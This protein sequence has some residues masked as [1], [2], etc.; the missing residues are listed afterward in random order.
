MPEFDP[1]QDL[2]DTVYGRL[3]EAAQ[4]RVQVLNLA[5]IESERIVI[6][7]FPW[8]AGIDPPCVVVAPY[9]E[10]VNWPEGTNEKDDV[11][12]G[13]SVA[14]FKAG[15][16]TVRTG[17]GFQLMWRQTTRRAMHNQS[18]GTWAALDNL[19]DDATFLH[20]YV[21]SPGQTFYEEAKK[22]GFDAHSW[23]VLFRVREPR[24]T[25]ADFDS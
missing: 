23:L 18:L 20:S 12:Y 5:N 2:A 7:E 15:G 22:R 24:L 8:P 14:F 25:D 19:P 3:L 1:D 6:R 17:L 13:V 4:E 21:T 11:I 9:Y 16:D 10:Q